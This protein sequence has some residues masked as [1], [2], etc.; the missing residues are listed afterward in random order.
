MT[1]G[2]EGGLGDT[3]GRL[4]EEQIAEGLSRGMQVFVA[5]RGDVVVDAAWGTRAQDDE[6]CTTTTRFCMFSAS[7]SITATAI[8][9]LVERGRLVYSDPIAVHVPEFEAFG[10]ETITIRDALLHQAG[11][12]D[13]FMQ[14]V[15]VTAFADWDAAV[16]A[17]CSLAPESSPGERFVYHP[18]AIWGVLGEVVA[19]VDGRSFEQF[20]RD[21]IFDPLG[22]HR[23]TWALPPDVRSEG[24]TVVS[25]AA[26]LD[27]F[28][29]M[30]MSEEALAAVAPG[31]NAYST[32]SDW[33]RYYLSLRPQATQRILSPATVAHATRRHAAM[34][35][36]DKTAALGYGFTIGTSQEASIG[37]GHLASDA[38][39]GHPG[40]CTVQAWCDP[41]TDVVAVLLANV[42]PLQDAA[43][44]RFNVLSDAIHRAVG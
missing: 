36:P 40:F 39:F 18:L 22:M 25:G 19:R 20:C 32:A 5:H 26:E 13:S 37:R 24:T 11:V 35:T 2:V 29:D 3:L 17:A 10:K 1:A 14:R 28:L 8:H 12:P 23:T 33:G 38:L 15:P 4:V 7:K 41:E 34:G 43:D 44:R 27:G 30:W 42:A 9:V 16:A 31:G 21:E 6:A